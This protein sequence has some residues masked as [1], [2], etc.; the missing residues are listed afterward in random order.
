M[1]E[2]VIFAFIV[3]TIGWACYKIIDFIR[4][5]IHRRNCKKAASEECVEQ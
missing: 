1:K 2:F 3:L 4:W 5:I